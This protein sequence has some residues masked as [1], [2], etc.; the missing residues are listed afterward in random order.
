M[1]LP[2]VICRKL[3]YNL[4][5]IFHIFPTVRHTITITRTCV[6]FPDLGWLYLFTNRDSDSSSSVN[7]KCF[8]KELWGSIVDP[9]DTFIEIVLVYV[10][11]WLCAFCICDHRQ[12]SHED[13]FLSFFLGVSSL[14]KQI[15][16][17]GQ[18]QSQRSCFVV[19]SIVVVIKAAWRVSHMSCSFFYNRGVLG[20]VSCFF[21]IKL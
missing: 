2:T 18:Q 19:A 6:V 5:A 20:E 16:L 10:C 12:S 13:G 14:H 7:T 15:F 17:L 9:R 3:G 8:S 1:R 21:C 4:S 11:I